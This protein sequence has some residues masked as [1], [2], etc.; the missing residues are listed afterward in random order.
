MHRYIHSLQRPFF[1]PAIGHTSRGWEM[2]GKQAKER[3]W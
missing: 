2:T 3:R 1:F